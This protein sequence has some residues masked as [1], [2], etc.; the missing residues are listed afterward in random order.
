[1]EIPVV[2]LSA[3][4]VLG[5]ACFGLVIGN[6]VKRLIPALDR[7]NIPTSVVGGFLYAAA[8]LALRGRVV[9]FEFDMVLRDILMIAFFTSVGMAASLRLIRIGGKRVA[10]FLAAAAGGLFAQLTFGAL[11]CWALGYPPLMGV[12][13]GNMTMAGGPATALAFG[14]IFEQAGVAGASALG[15]AAAVYGI[16]AGGLTGGHVGGTLIRRHSLKPVD[17]HLEIPSDLQ[18]IS[19]P[20]DSS[21]LTNIIA[22]SIA[23]ALGSI[24]SAKFTEWEITLPAYIGAMI[25]AGVLRNVDEVTHWFR[26]DQEQ[27]AEIGSIALEI[28]I[29]MAL[30]TL[31]LWELQN[32]VLPV[33]G[34]LIGQTLLTI[35][36]AWFVVFRLMGGGYVGA[37]MSAGFTG[38]MLGTTA[39]AMACMGEVVRKFGPAPQAFFVVSIVGAFLI[40][41]INAL[42]I[43]GALNFLR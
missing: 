19:D 18:L 11:A 6:A 42:L 29:V 13:A 3:I 4:Q 1:V 15:L 26:I 8:V 43:N 23:M 25:T 35:V 28:F 30:L 41:F 36:L 7:L 40:D 24:V 22:L 10:I 17:E 39:N 32:L 9:N 2:K 12:V 21:Y 34:I 16:V 14:P 27:M 37:V 33:F 5:I 31:R 38:F 20:T